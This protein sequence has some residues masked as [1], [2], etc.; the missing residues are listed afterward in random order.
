MPVDIFAM[1]NVQKQWESEAPAE[2]APHGFGSSFTRL[3][4]PG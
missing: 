2:L 4:L 3:T 1:P